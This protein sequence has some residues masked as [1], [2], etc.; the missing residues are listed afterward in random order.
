[1]DE[2]ILEEMI[3]RCSTEGPQ[4]ALER[5]LIEE[6]LKSKG[7]TMRDLENLPKD[8]AHQ[9][10]IEACRYASLKLTEIESRAKFRKDIRAP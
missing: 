9:L 5:Q 2:D 7:Y 3:K 1:M 10:R 4:S 6:Y 8:T